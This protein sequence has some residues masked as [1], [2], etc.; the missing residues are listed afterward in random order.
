M[1]QRSGMKNV[2]VPRLNKIILLLR[3]GLKG[4]Q[5][6]M[7]GRGGSGFLKRNRKDLPFCEE[8]LRSIARL[9]KAVRG[10]LLVK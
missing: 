2:L 7:E 1:Q 10:D 8:A 3:K 6:S 4:K 9:A 5:L